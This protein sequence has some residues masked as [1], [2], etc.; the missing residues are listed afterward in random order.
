M[1]LLDRLPLIIFSATGL[2][3]LS[4]CFGNQTEINPVE[5]SA[6]G[7][8]YRIYPNDPARTDSALKYMAHGVVIPALPGAA[9]TLNIDA[10]SSDVPDLRLYRLFPQGDQ[11]GY[12]TDKLVRAKVNGNEWTYEFQ[13]D[14]TSFNNWLTVLE[15]DGERFSGTLTD[16]HLSAKGE[17]G[18]HLVLNVWIAGM[19]V[20]P[21]SGE[22]SEELGQKLLSGYRKYYGSA[23]I[24]IDTLIVRKA[25]EHPLAGRHFKDTEFE[26]SKDIGAR[27]DS[28][29]FGLSGASNGAL[30][31]V[32]VY[33][34]ESE[35]ML[36]LS[37]LFGC[38]LQGGESGV[39][40]LSTHRSSAGMQGFTAVTSDDMT[41]TAIHESGHFLGL[42]HT[43]ITNRDREVSGDY[44]TFEDGLTDTPW[45]PALSKM[46]AE[47]SLATKPMVVSRYYIASIV[48]D[49]CPD[50]SNPMFPYSVD[51]GMDLFTPEQAS[52]LVKNLSLFPH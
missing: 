42:R 5:P 15:K 28:L 24:I 26:I 21:S 37:P 1:K 18:S 29:G 17:Y 16:M 48:N 13:S 44:S 22:S 7:G 20:P 46:V 14:H 52:I 51:G 6:L 39:V 40:L 47:D 31:L 34:F 25:T 30:D 27:Y 32:V 45:C 4:G 35:G 33:G 41:F 10:H 38:N 11:Y 2:V 50:A 8:G 49:V 36:G 19:Y 23:G 3:A 12:A 9:Y 43:T